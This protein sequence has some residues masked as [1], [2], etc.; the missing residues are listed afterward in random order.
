MSFIA[1]AHEPHVDFGSVSLFTWGVHNSSAKLVRTQLTFVGQF[2][3]SKPTV[4]CCLKIDPFWLEVQK[5]LD[6]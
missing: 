5:L 1:P 4:L 3:E 2:F 6:S